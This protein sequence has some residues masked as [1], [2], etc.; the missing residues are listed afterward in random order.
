[1]TYSE[2]RGI[3]PFNWLEA[4]QPGLIGSSGFHD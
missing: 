1:M 3:A 2:Q 4:L